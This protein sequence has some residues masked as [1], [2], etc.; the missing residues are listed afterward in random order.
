ME[1]L[2]FQAVIANGLFTKLDTFILFFGR[3]LLWHILCKQPIL[4]PLP[5]ELAFFRLSQLIQIGILIIYDI[6]LFARALSQQL[7]QLISNLLRLATIGEKLLVIFLIAHV[8]LRRFHAKVVVVEVVIGG[9]PLHI[10][11]YHPLHL[12]DLIIV[13][14]HF[15]VVDVNFIFI[16]GVTCANLFLLN[17][18]QLI[19]ISD[20][21]D[22]TQIYKFFIIIILEILLLVIPE[23]IVLQSSL[24]IALV[25]LHIL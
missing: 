23:A 11:P 13:K 17:G 18:R 19:Q 24:R 9:I 21:L 25:F 2:G 12:L 8:A 1:V 7:P 3:L 5:P 20:I 16:F 4:Q 6:Q 22:I 15:D 14:V 10:C